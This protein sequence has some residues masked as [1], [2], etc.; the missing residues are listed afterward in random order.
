MVGKS[1]VR[2]LVRVNASTWQVIVIR[3]WRESSGIRLRILMQDG[4]NRNWA[5]A[6]AAEAGELIARLIDELEAGSVSPHTPS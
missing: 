2:T 4:T 6:T 1:V 5:V 3:V